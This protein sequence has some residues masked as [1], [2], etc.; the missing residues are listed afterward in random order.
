MDVRPMRLTL[1]EETQDVTYPH[2]VLEDEFVHRHRGHASLH[3]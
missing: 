1:A 3:M 2:R